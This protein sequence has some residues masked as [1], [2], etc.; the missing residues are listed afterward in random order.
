MKHAFQKTSPALLAALVG[1]GQGRDAPTGEVTFSEL[2]APIVYRSCLPC[3]RAGESAPF[4]L[5]E[6]PEV[7]KRARQIVQVTGD[8]YMPPWLQSAGHGE[9][10]GDRSLSDEEIATIARWFEA[11]APEGDP[12]KLPPAP[13]ATAGWQL[14][15]PDLVLTMPEPFVLSEEGLDVF[16]NFVLPVPVDRARY[17]EAVELR[18]GNKRVVHHAVMRVDRTSW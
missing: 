7:A 14:G 12:A 18:P 1:L 10:A 8:R 17:V 4:Q 13:K 3:H 11:G 2:V 9:F 5:L 6:Y 16:R 15:E